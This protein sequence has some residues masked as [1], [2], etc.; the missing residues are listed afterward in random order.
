MGGS[1]AANQSVSSSVYSPLPSGVQRP[2]SSVE[3]VALSGEL[4][5]SEGWLAQ[6]P[7]STPGRVSAFHFFY[8]L[9]SV[10]RCGYDMRDGRMTSQ[11]AKA[12]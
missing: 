10:L 3:R 12:N 7:G 2:D 1:D 5:N 11:A 4:S 8:A 6:V 9:L